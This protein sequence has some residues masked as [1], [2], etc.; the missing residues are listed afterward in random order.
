MERLTLRKFV[1]LAPA[2]SK[3]LDW[4]I[5]EKELVK[6]K[7]GRLETRNQTTRCCSNRKKANL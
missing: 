1:S 2:A 4:L 5:E 7:D 3:N 6:L